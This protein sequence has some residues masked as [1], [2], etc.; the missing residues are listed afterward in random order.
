MLARAPRRHSGGHAGSPRP[1]TTPASEHGY[2]TDETG[3]SIPPGQ[4]RINKRKL[5]WS[6][7]P[8][9]AKK[10]PSRCTAR[11][12]WS[13][14]D[15]KVIWRILTYMCIT[16]K[17]SKTVRLVNK[18]AHLLATPF[19]FS[20][21]HVSPSMNSIRR[22]SN[23]GKHAELAGCVEILECHNWGLA[24]YYTDDSL[25]R[26]SLARYFASISTVASPRE[27]L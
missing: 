11:V 18:A 21:V 23:I 10:P 14:L 5:S 25:F 16:P 4:R 2:I 24:E 17:G 13:I 7:S 12:D 8:P 15:Q 22:L 9:P 26:E 27:L 6:P 19:L 3:S 20:R 1:L